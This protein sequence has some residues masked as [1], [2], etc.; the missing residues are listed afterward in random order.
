MKRISVI[1][2]I[3]LLCFLSAGQAIMENTHVISSSGT[4]A[5]KQNL[6]V[7]VLMYHRIQKL[8]PDDARNPLLKELTVEPE[9]FEAQMKY[10]HESGF[11]VISTH[12]IQNMVRAGLPIPE[13][14]LAITFDDGYKNNFE[15]AFPIL[16][17]YGFIA[18]IFV[19]TRAIGTPGHLTWD[20]CARMLKAGFS[21]ESHTVHHSDLTTLNPHELDMELEQSASSI[22]NSL[23]INV[24][25]LA[26]PSG[27]YDK[28]V[29]AAMPACGYAAGWKKDGGPVHLK[30]NIYLLPRIRVIG[31]LPLNGFKKLINHAAFGKA[32]NHVKS[33][34]ISGVK[35]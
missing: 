23:G 29:V 9:D 11:T 35:S 30:E 2:A 22:Y 25:S 13:K 3:L 6:S 33:K 27:R 16:R 1:T 20:D 12:D 34:A 7:P 19:V 4:A 15:V 10:I 5:K 21:I 32:E 17:K 24:T 26:Y 28:N 31:G 14:A 8:S 18:T